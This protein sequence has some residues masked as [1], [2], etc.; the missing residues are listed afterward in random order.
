MA[1]NTPL[2]LDGE[3]GEKSSTFEF[4]LESL[5]D[6]PAPRVYCSLLTI[7]D[8]IFV[9]GG[10]D[11]TGKSLNNVF[12]YSSTL[13]VWTEWPVMIRNR[14]GSTAVHSNGLII[15]IG[16][17]DEKQSAIIDIDC[18]NSKTKLWSRISA[19]PT[20]VV[21]CGV[22]I[23][24]NRIYVVGGATTENVSQSLFG[25]FDLSSYDWVSLQN[26]PT[27]RYAITTYI[28]ND[29]LIVIGGRDILKAMVEVEAYDLIDQC[30]R[31]LAAIP[32]RRAYA[33]TLG[34][35]QYIYHVGG[36]S[37]GVGTWK[38]NVRKLVE[39]F[40]IIHNS[41]TKL[42]PLKLRRTDFS[43]C[44]FKDN[45]IVA[46][47]VSEQNEQM[48]PISDSENYVMLD[49]KWESVANL[50]IPRCSMANCAFYDGLLII[51]GMGPGGP[52]KKVEII[53][54]TSS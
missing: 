35:D 14:S 8:Q 33:C 3:L 12:V 45:L 13:K 25:Y 31:K 42:K 40:D 30:W 11:S 34:F 29:S 54:S 18:L 49:N 48:V 9:F 20:A 17:I 16:G 39:R 10:C 41:W 53:K 2:N 28:F 21:G 6:L 46:G 22:C 37:E 32:S 44:I 7:D 38:P 51:G 52:Q 4:S 47:G 23:N 26:L 36:V 19:L 27:P 15:L 43:A 50:S 1:S 5:P 24:N